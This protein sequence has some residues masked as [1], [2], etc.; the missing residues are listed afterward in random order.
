MSAHVPPTG[1]TPEEIFRRSP[2]KIIPHVDL[3]LPSVF[4]MARNLAETSAK[5]ATA[6]LRGETTIRSDEAASRCE[7]ICKASGPNGGPCQFFRVKDSRCSKCGCCGGGVL[8]DMWKV[9]QKHC[10]LELW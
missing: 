6:K 4:T 8:L 10:P 3:Q 7:S 2:V 5:V 1:P 9:E